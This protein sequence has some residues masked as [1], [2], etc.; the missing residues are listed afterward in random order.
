MRY[1]IARI[2]LWSAVKVAFVIFTALA[3]VMGFV[4]SIIL[5]AI[6]GVLQRM[7]PEGLELMGMMRLP[8]VLMFFTSILLAPIYGVIATLAVTVAVLLYNTVARW[9]GGLAM[10]LHPE[11]EDVRPAFRIPTPVLSETDYDTGN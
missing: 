2:D 5:L 9:T 7:V 4:W 6:G 11:I 3:L 1:R 8:A 10:A